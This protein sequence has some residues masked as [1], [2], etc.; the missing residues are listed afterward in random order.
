MVRSIETDSFASSYGYVLV[1]IVTVA[2]EFLVF[3]RFVVDCNGRHLLMDFVRRDSVQDLY[4]IV[5]MSVRLWSFF[6]FFEYALPCRA[7]RL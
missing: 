3:T 5:F 7:P 4:R 1:V 2:F 6:L